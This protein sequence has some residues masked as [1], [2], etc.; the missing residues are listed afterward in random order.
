VSVLGLLA[1][2]AGLAAAV[3]KLWTARAGRRALRERRDENASIDSDV[4]GGDGAAVSAR[5]RLW[6]AEDD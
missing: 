2:L 3:L 5:L 1:A 4:R 6:R